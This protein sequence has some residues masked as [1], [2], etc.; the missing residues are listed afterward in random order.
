MAEPGSASRELSLG[1]ALMWLNDRL[2]EPM[3]VSLDVERGDYSTNVLAIEAG[4]LRHWREIFASVARR[5]HSGDDN[6]GLYDVGGASLDLTD[7]EG[8]TVTVD[9]DDDRIRIALG[10]DVH[11]TILHLIETGAEDG[12]R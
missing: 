12:H 9:A 5:R 6:P 1:E 11:L 4:S 7:L 8:F 3:V 10:E 2:G